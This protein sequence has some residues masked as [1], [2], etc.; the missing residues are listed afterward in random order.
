MGGLLTDALRAVTGAEISFFPA[1][2]YGATLL[3]GPI[4]VED[5]YNLVPTDGRIIT[6]SM[7]G[8]SI[9]RLM[10]N[11]L[12]GVV[13]TDPYARVG[14][15]M[16]QFSGMELTYDL[17]NT[18]G[19]RVVAARWAGSPSSRRRLYSVASVH[20]RFQNNLLF[21]AQRV[22]E[23][24]PVFVEALIEYIRDQLAPE[25]DHGPQDPTERVGHRGFLIAGD[26]PR[27]VRN[28]EPDPWERGRP[29]R[30]G[31]HAPAAG[32]PFRAFG[33]DGR[34]ARAPGGNSRSLKRRKNHGGEDQATANALAEEGQA[35]RRLQGEGAV[36]PSLLH[37]SRPGGR[38]R[39]EVQPRRPQP[40]HP[41]HA[42][43]LRRRPGEPVP[44]CPPASPTIRCS[45]SSSRR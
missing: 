25:A 29:A 21:G 44:D 3:P 9:E 30:L 22:D 19:E 36:R 31:S 4:A 15:D 10:E 12:D 1:W 38:G 26:A 13:D 32:R 40:V 11:I 5:V 7:S 39:D 16:I 35:G 34:D 20:T 45:P 43:V 8:R 24:G 17:Y 27:H 14:G 37:R 28:L 33:P 42:G 2:R 41:E 23:N 6:Y 18:D